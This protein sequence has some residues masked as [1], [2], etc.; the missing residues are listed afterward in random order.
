MKLMLMDCEPWSTVQPGEEVRDN[1]DSRKVRLRKLWQGKVAK[2]SLA[3]GDEKQEH[4]QHPFKQRSKGHS[5]ELQRLYA[6]EDSRRRML[7]L[8]RQLCIGRG[9]QDLL[10]V[11]SDLHRRNWEQSLTGSRNI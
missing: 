11:R 2:I 1:G 4:V 5:G 8:R 10:Q 6:P 3:I 9:L 7:Q